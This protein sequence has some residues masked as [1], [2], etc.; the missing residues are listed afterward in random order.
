LLGICLTIVAIQ[1]SWILNHKES[2]GPHEDK[3]E[4]SF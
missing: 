4:L 3:L 2:Q 1:R